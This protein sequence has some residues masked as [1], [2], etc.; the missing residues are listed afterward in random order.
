MQEKSP[1]T[2]SHDAAVT[3]LGKE[4]LI[5]PV[6]VLALM[7]LAPS[8]VK[9]PDIS[10]VIL[11]VEKPWTEPPPETFPSMSSLDFPIKNK[12]L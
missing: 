7:V 11:N 3:P 8:F 5:E 10:P 1:C 4:V 2:L 9:V 12:S 6:M